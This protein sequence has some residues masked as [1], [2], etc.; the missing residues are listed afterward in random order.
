LKSTHVQAY[1]DYDAPFGHGECTSNVRCAEKKT[2]WC[3]VKRLCHRPKGFR[4]GRI[5]ALVMRSFGMAEKALEL[6]HATGF[7][8]HR[9]G[10]PLFKLGGNGGSASQITHCM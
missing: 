1:G 10:R 3:L 8:S 2:Y 5:H 7:K 6:S 4:S 9:F